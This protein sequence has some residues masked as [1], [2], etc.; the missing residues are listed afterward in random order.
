MTTPTGRPKG[1]RAT[2]AD[3]WA[4]WE[5]VIA[6][7]VSCNVDFGSLIRP[8]N[9]DD[10][11]VD[12]QTYEQG[13]EWLRNYPSYFSYLY[14]PNPHI[15]RY[16]PRKTPTEMKGWRKYIKETY[17]ELFTSKDPHACP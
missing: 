10:P 7:M 2:N 11:V 1:R 6:V 16:V 13:G 15:E 14:S 3:D 4:R 9:E 8:A 5:T 17:P 12:I